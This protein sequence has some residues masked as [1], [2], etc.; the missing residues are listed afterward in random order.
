MSPQACP[1]RLARIAT[2]VALAFPLL[3][4]AQAATDPAKPADSSPST[5]APKPTPQV[6]QPVQSLES[7][8][9]RAR[10]RDETEQGVP[11]SV[12]VFSAKAIEDAGIKKPGDFVALTPN[13]SL[14]ETQSVGTSFM[15]IR[16]LSQVRNGEAPMAV[17][18]DGVI[19]SDAKQFTQ[20]LFDIQTIE[21]LRGPQGALYGRNA[22]GGAILIRTK[23]PTN[24]TQGFVQAT[25]GTGNEKVLQGAVSGAIVSDKLFYRLAGSATDRG[26]YFENAYLGS[27]ADPY[28]DQTFR[29]LLKWNVNDDFTLDLRTNFVRDRAGG[30]NFQYQPTHLFA[31]CTADPANAFDFTLLDPN[32]VTRTFCANNFGRNTRDMDEVTLKADY[33]LGFATLTGVLS[34]NRVTED[35]GGDQ[36]PYTGSRNLFGQFD[37]TQTQFVDVK[38]DSVDVRLTS[39]TRKGIRWVAGVYGLKTERFISTTTGSDLGLGVADITHDPAFSSPTNPTLSWFADNDHNRA[40]AAYGNVDYDIT[41]KL[42]GSVAIRYDRDEREQVVDY[43]QSVG[44]PPGC[45]AADIAACTKHATYSAMQPK[46]SLR[47]KADDGSLLYASVGK[48]FR[49]GQFN[50]SGVGVAAAAATP[51]VIGVSDE[52]GAEITKSL[53]VGYKTELAGGKIRLNTALFKTQVTNAPYFVFIG[54]VGAQ[55]LVPINKVD[56]VGGEFEAVAS[57]APGLDAYAGFGITNS[58]IKSYSVNPAAVGNRAPYVPDESANVGAQY[59]FPVG[60]GM[61]VFLRGDVMLKGKQYWD[62]EN[63]VSR[64]AVTLVNLRAGLED[65]GG[66]W[67][68]TLSVNNAFDKAYNAE[69]VAGGFAVPALPRIVRLDVRYNF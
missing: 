43:R 19:Q 16:G 51:P 46:V 39:P 10:G 5:T 40:T 49:S 3:A 26:G 50:Q 18:V 13:L 54:A 9:I 1:A 8:V 7:V 64:S 57:L 66:K 4:Q 28:K 55:V 48:G 23:Q 41:P 24:T 69:W 35:L 25:Y 32:H 17:V 47:Y 45:T 21:V 29:G 30:G 53:E 14:V 56:I 62:P 58:K 33:E 61:R 6:D 36:F 31:D 67:N 42:E 34:H 68:A 65:A 27:K 22:S 38:S 2:A 20:D 44:L 52:I 37:G 60:Y 11:L 15:T 59:R 12:K 63:S